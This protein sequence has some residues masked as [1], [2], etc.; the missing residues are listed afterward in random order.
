MDSY[1]TLHIRH[2]LDRLVARLRYTDERNPLNVVEA[3]QMVEDAYVSLLTI[4]ERLD[5]LEQVVEPE[6]YRTEKGDKL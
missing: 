2:E 1:D 3:Y 4:A 6:K 5:R